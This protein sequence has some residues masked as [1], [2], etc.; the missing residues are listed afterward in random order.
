M[1]MVTKTFFKCKKNTDFSSLFY[2]EITSHLTLT[3]TTFCS[4]AILLCSPGIRNLHDELLRHRTALFYCQ[5]KSC[6]LLP[7]I[8][9]HSKTTRESKSRDF[10]LS[11][12]FIFGLVNLFVRTRYLSSLAE[13]KIVR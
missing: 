9:I 2:K 6:V 4:A 12:S 8:C 13:R 7:C 11:S 3:A 5:R 10:E 1:T